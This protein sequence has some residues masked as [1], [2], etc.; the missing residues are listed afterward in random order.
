MSG[1]DLNMTNPSKNHLVWITLIV[2][3]VLFRAIG[4]L[5]VNIDA[6]TRSAASQKQEL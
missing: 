2:A 3:P 4:A 5:Q 6:R 1:S